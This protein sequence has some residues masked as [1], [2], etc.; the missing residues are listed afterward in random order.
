VTHPYRDRPLAKP[1]RRAA[2]VRLDVT[3]VAF[4]LCCG[5]IG[6]ALAGPGGAL[7]I[8]VLGVL[9]LICSPRR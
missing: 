8:T 4:G 1:E 7:G 5:I 9:I 2:E 6:Q 3:S